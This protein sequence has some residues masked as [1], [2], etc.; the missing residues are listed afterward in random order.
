[1]AL[2]FQLI[3]LMKICHDIIEYKKGSSLPWDM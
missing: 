3:G 1:M 2:H